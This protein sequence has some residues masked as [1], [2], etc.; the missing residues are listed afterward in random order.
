ML[1]YLCVR[2]KAYALQAEGFGPKQI[3]N[4]QQ[5]GYNLAGDGS[6]GSSL[7][8]PSQ[9][10]D[11]HRVQNHVERASYKSGKHGKLR[12][13]VCADNGIH[14]IGKHEKGDSRNEI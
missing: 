12:A 1:Q 7:H 11:G 2:L 10:K 13:A 14:G 8:S 6:Q 5:G 9:H 3:I 4:C